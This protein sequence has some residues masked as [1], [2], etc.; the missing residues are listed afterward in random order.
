MRDAQ[1]KQS[2]KPWGSVAALLAACFATIAGV[3]RGIDPDVILWR[4]IVAATLVAAL[5]AVA[6]CVVQ[7]LLRSW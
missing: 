3:V 4:A 6:N 1:S 7:W 2:A 5:A